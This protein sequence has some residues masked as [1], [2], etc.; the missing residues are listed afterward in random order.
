MRFSFNAE[1]PFGRGKLMGRNVN[2]FVNAFI[3]NWKAAGLGSIQSGRPWAALNGSGAGFPDDVGSIRAN[4][5]PGVT[6]CIANPNWRNQ[7]NDT[8]QRWSRYYMVDQMFMPAS[9][10]SVGNVPRTLDA[11][12][13]PWSQTFNA[14]LLKEFVFTEQ[15]RLQ[16]RVEAFSVLNHVNFVGNVNSTSMFTALDYQNYVN[17]PVDVVRNIATNYTS[18]TQNIG[19]TRTM[20][21]GLKLYF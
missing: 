14:S 20:Q 13:M 10:F 17:P 19:P 8:K 12:R 21:I 4:W 9:R 15:I 1:L 3:G 18:M 2:K 11:C 16:L 6:G 5:K 7:L